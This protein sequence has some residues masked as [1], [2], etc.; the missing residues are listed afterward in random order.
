MSYLQPNISVSESIEIIKDKIRTK[1]P[2]SFTRFGDGEIYVLNKNGYKFHNWEKNQLCGLWGYSYPDEVQKGY[3]EIGKIIKYSLKNT[4]MIGI[5]SEKHEIFNGNGIEFNPNTWSLSINY[6]NSIDINFKDILVGEH[7]LPRY[8][9]FGNIFEF[10]KIID[11]S[12]I[13]IISSKSKLLKDKNLSKLLGVNVTYTDHPHEINVNNRDSI[14]KSFESIPS[15]I[16]ILGCGYLKDYGPILTKE[17]GKISLDFGATLDAW[18]GVISRPW[19]KKGG[20][21]DYLLI[22]N[23]SSDLY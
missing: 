4:D 6:L 20:L 17:F 18:A 3:N 13:H 7:M 21:Q 5:M 22:D 15:Q 9:E 16:V 8:K 23:L 1:T 12:D 10:S 2:F 11:G 14:M 19:F